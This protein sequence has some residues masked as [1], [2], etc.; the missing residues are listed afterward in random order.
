MK[1][2]VAVTLIIGAIVLIALPALSDAYRATLITRLLEHGS[3]TVTIVGEMG[4]VY[5]CSCWVIGV[6]MMLIAVMGSLATPGATT[7]IRIQ[8]EVDQD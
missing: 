6:L 7:A 1:P 5:R 3:T 2:P 4:D 8:P